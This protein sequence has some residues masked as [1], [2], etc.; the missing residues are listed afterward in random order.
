MTA[1]EP[2]VSLPKAARAAGKSRSAFRRAVLALHAQDA[3]DRAD[4]SWL[5]IRF[6]RRRRVIRLNM[7]RLRAAH[8]G[9]FSRQWVDPHELVSRLDENEKRIIELEKALKA[10]RAEIRALGFG[11]TWIGANRGA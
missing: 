11:R 1:L 5:V 7:S 4:T 9:H 10:S 6:V 2:L 3:N 8:P